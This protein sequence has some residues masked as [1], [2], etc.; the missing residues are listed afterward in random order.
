M[1]HRTLCVSNA[2]GLRPGKAAWLLLD[3]LRGLEWFY[4]GFI[5][6]YQGF[7]GFYRG[8]IRF[9]RVILGLG[10]LLWLLSGPRSYGGFSWGLKASKGGYN[11][12]EQLEQKVCVR[13][14]MAL[15]QEFFVSKFP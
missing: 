4:G 3:L 2:T 12:F 6:F 1:G 7:Y 15:A 8:F 5:G 14:A 11:L 10:F 9:Y 13:L